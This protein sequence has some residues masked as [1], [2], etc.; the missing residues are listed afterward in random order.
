MFPRALGLALLVSSV[1]AVALGWLLVRPTLSIPVGHRAPR[2]PV[3]DQPYRLHDP[4]VG[5]TPKTH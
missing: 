5:D 3:L 2:P 4:A 1:L